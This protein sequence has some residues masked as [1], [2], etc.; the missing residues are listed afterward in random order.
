MN[1]LQEGGSINNTNNNN[2]VEE[3]KVDKSL[4]F[5]NPTAKNFAV[6]KEAWIAQL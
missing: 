1:G 2:H 5:S 6:N 3:E 4:L